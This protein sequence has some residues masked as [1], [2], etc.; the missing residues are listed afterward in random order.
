MKRPAPPQWFLFA[1]LVVAA[2]YRE[3]PTPGTDL[4][5]LVVLLDSAPRTLDP[6][7][8]IDATSMKVS[9]MVFSALVTVDNA[10]LEPK[11]DLAESI[12]E[13]PNDPRIWHVRVRQGVRFHDGVELTGSDVVYTFRSVLDPALGS[14]YRADFSRKIKDVRPDPAGDAYDVLFEV[15]TPYATF[16]TDLVL[17]IVPRHCL[18]G[19]TDAAGN[20]GVF[21]EGEYIGTGPFRYVRRDGERKV[22]L[23]RFADAY[24]GAPS[25]RWLVFKTIEDENT[26]LLALLGGSGDLLQNSV[27]PV[28]LDVLSDRRGI[29]VETARSISFTYIGLNLRIPALADLRVRRALAHGIDRE[30]IIEHRFAGKARLATG[31]LAPFHWCYEGG[32]ET[33]PYDPQKAEALLDDA[34]Y[35]RSPETGVRLTIELKLSNNRFRRSV[36]EMMARQLSRIGVEVTLRSFEFGTFLADVRKGNFDLFLLQLPE[37][38]EPDMLRWMLDS[39]NTPD[40]APGGARTPYELADRRAFNPGYEALLGDPVCGEWARM[41]RKRGEE[42]LQRGG[43]GGLDMGS[44]NRTYFFDPRFDCMVELGQRTPDREAR[45]RYYSEAQQIAARELP[46]IPLWHEDNIAVMRSKVHDYEMLP[47]GR[48]TTLARVRIGGDGP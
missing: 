31:M 6:R 44:A 2:C 28:L 19:V 46:V 30:A 12:R 22:L 38:I 3:Q 11:P 39:M 18:E 17:G 5:R 35:R 29:E 7:F 36:A 21:P 40:K 27:S 37:P 48:L 1:L 47:N 24:V 14:P 25:Y 32:V 4:D 43:D 16:V 41:V 10:R 15:Q 45:K 34:G 9:R 23:E 26:R 42:A 13:D 8:T 20:V 33:Y